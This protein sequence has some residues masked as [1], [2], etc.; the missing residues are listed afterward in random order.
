MRAVVGVTAVYV[1]WIPLAE[2]TLV[3]VARATQ[4]TLSWLWSPPLITTL[5]VSG[6]TIDLRGLLDHPNQWMGRW[7]AGNL[8]IFIIAALG[9]A[10]AV[11]VRDL[12]DRVGLVGGTLL[13]CFLMMVGI[14]AVEVLTVSATFAF[15]AERLALLSAAE[16]A[17]LA[18]ALGTID[19][20]QMLLPATVALIAYGFQW[21]DA[22]SSVV[23]QA[24]WRSAAA[25]WTALVVVLAMLMLPTRAPSPVARLG[26]FERTAELNPDS[27][28]AWLAFARAAARRPGAQGAVE[29]YRRALENGADSRVVRPGLAR[30]LLAQKRPEEALAAAEAGLREGPVTPALLAAEATAL[31]TLGRGC[32]AVERLD[33]ALPRPGVAQESP[34]LVGARAVAQ[35][36]CRESAP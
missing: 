30:S 36:R 9:L 6:T 2:P 5:E 15:G 22:D 8:P 13:V 26:R 25:I 16:R 12:A 27:G 3:V 32:E 17:F 31:T 7:A 19:L 35:R 28:A 11:P 24:G 33:R 18:S 29:A 23:R 1:L 14:S 21:A 4:S 10:V 34:G 20:I